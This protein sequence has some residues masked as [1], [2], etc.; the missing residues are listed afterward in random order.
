MRTKL[1]VCMT[2][3]VSVMFAQYPIINGIST[4]PAN[5]VN[6]Q[7]PSKKNNFFDWQ[8]EIWTVK[9]LANQGNCTRSN[10]ITSPFF[11]VDNLEEL[12]E[13]KDMSWQDGWE[14]IARRVGLSEQNTDLVD[15]DVDI[16]VVLYNRYRGILRVLLQTCRG[17]DYNAASVSIKFDNTSSIKTDLLEF[18]RN[19]G[20]QPLAK[21]FTPLEFSAVSSYANNNTKWFYADFPMMYDPCTSS[22]QS[23]IL[24]TSHLV[25]TSS[26]TISGAINGE[27]LTK[28]VG[29]KAELAKNGST[30]WSD[31][32]FPGLA[33]FSEA[34]P[35][36]IKF[37][38]NALKFIN[39]QQTNNSGNL[40]A[41]QLFSQ[42]LSSHKFLTAGMSLNPWLRGALSVFEM[43][44]SGGK[45]GNANGPQVVKIMPMAINMTAALSGN[46]STNLVYHSIKINNPGAKDN[47]F[48]P[49]IYPYYNEVLGIF[50]LLHM[51]EVYWERREEN[52]NDYWNYYGLACPT[53][54]QPVMGQCA[55]FRV[56]V[57]RFKLD[58]TT[59]KY[60][61]NPASGL[62]IQ[63]MQLQLI[64]E[65]EYFPSYYQGQNA[66][67][68]KIMPSDFTYEGVDSRTNSV[69]FSSELLHAKAFA[70]RTFKA[71]SNVSAYVPYP[72]YSYGSLYS[73][74][75]PWRP[76]G[77]VLG[78]TTVYL[79]VFLNLKVING[80]P[81]TQNVLYVLTYPVKLKEGGYMQYWENVTSYRNGVPQDTTLIKSASVLEVNEFCNDRTVYLT[82]AR[83][84][85]AFIDSINQNAAD[86]RKNYDNDLLLFPNPS[87]GQFSIKLLP[88][89]DKLLAIRVF[90][91]KGNQVFE[92]NGRN[93]VLTKGYS[94]TFSLNLP[95][96]SYFIILL[97]NKRAYKKALIISK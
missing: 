17:E 61:I 48:D 58:T 97:T 24:I 8:S 74:W 68:E 66:F 62:V 78:D 34:F 53:P 60:V 30:S 32:A 70:K 85:Q 95:K 36:S 44:S 3:F 64:T 56:N 55:A 43:F 72:T 65:G 18:S 5:P 67:D 21:Q 80:G 50:N 57:D 1:V 20:I 90:S 40:S 19:G 82:T 27:I 69:K 33:K 54:N 2:L 45:T 42:T 76:K 13:S 14:L 47:E 25:S 10:S 9:S 41:F 81:N 29:G 86:K 79:K 4:N 37:V 96:G 77:K 46:I 63:N 38:S 92:I 88:S 12:R 71:I 15:N 16:A 51:P 23:K 75:G 35:D 83:L 84:S 59:F 39:N 6:T 11:R 52:L 49:A 89:Q 91:S 22:F 87:N 28:D 73:Y 31:F 94:K 93:E 7:L 26:I